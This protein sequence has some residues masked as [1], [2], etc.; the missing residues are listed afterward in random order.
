MKRV[1]P[2]GRHQNP[3]G[4]GSRAARQATRARRSSVTNTA[5]RACD[6]AMQA[7]WPL[8]R[9]AVTDALRRRK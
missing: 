3:D 6:H 2:D 9:L 5:P 1:V 4:A 7:A 8:P